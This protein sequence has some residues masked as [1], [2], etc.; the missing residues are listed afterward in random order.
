MYIL[1]VINEDLRVGIE[2]AAVVLTDKEELKN[3]IVLGR[4]FFIL[5]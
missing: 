1:G 4:S 3:F 5:M 2:N